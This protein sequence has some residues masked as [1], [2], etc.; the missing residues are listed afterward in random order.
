MTN[1]H[2][3]VRN[4]IGGSFCKKCFDWSSHPDGLKDQ[5]CK[6]TKEEIK[7]NKKRLKIIY[8]KQQ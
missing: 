7:E 3:S 1:K 5:E 6:A 8:G 4:N 2:Y